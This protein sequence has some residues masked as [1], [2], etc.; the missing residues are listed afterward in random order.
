MGKLTWLAAAAL[1]TV[2]SCSSDSGDGDQAAD[3][4]VTTVTTV[5]TTVAAEAE[6]PTDTATPADETT[7]ADEAAAADPEWEMVQGDETCECADG[8]DYNLWVRDAGAT[9]VV[10]FFEGGGACFSAEM[11]AFGSGSYDYDVSDSD[12][13]SIAKGIFDFENPAN[14]FADWSVVFVPYCTGDVFLGASSHDYGGGLTVE[15][16]GMANATFGLDELE[17]RFPNADQIFVTGSSAGGV[18]APL[19]A[20]LA[21]DRFPDA[22]ITALSDGSGAYPAAPA[23][24]AAIGSLWG[25]FDARPDWPETADLTPETWSIPG[26]FTVAGTH[27]RDIV[28]ARHDHAFDSVQASFSAIA[29]ISADRLDV[30]IDGNAAEIEASGVPVA[31]FVAPGTTH[32]ILGRDLVYTQE[33]E[34]VRFIDWLTGLVEGTPVD[35]VHCTVCT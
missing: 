29:G 31:S 10:L 6:T 14:P 23:I 7:A 34:G 24:N 3:T 35:D 21:S 22:R 1:L 8:S 17:R 16:N 4:T 32:T 11:C 28:M 26:L 20:G 2:A 15:H 33:V 27:D 12:D 18:P 5:V 19:F 13:P 30:L 9:K 25:T